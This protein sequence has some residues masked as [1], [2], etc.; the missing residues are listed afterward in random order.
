MATRKAED[1]QKY[2]EE[3]QETKSKILEIK[4]GIWNSKGN[5]YIV[6]R[7]CSQSWKFKNRFKVTEKTNNSIQL[8]HT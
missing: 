4:K 7:Y 2:K 8:I 3:K 6:D 1:S 5:T